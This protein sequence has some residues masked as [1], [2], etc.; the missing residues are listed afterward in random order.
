MPEYLPLSPA[1]KEKFPDLAAQI[2]NFKDVTIKREV[3]ELEE[4]KEEVYEE[5]RGRWEIEKLRD[6]PDFRAYRDFFWKLGTDPTKNRPAAEA[7]IRRVLNGRPIPK[8]NTWVDAY[9]LVSIQTAIPIASF[10]ADLLEGSLLMREAEAGEEFLGIAMKKPMVLKGG[11]AVIQDDQG[12]VA[13]YPFR[14]ADHSKVTGDTKNVLMLLCGAPK[15]TLETLDA[16]AGVAEKVLTR[17]C[18]GRAE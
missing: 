12:L 7:L 14:D 16:S 4:Y 8:I 9:N 17:F 18:G 10:D 3:N 15:I 6:D 5:T 1:L 13:I 2:I 11:E